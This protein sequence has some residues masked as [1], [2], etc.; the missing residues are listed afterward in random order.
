MNHR[1]AVFAKGLGTS[2]KLYLTRV[3]FGVALTRL[4]I[5]FLCYGKFHLNTSGNL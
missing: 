5:L 4:Y 2:I 1:N 3:L